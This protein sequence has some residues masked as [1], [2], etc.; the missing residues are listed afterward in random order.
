M[1][2]RPIGDMF[3]TPDGALSDDQTIYSN[4]IKQIYHKLITSVDMELRNQ[5]YS[6]T[7]NAP[8]ALKDDM[9]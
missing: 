2:N 6:F 8:E 7:I 3:E 1:A 9:T 4:N 5:L